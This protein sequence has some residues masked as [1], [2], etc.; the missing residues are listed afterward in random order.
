[1]IPEATEDPTLEPPAMKPQAS[2][3]LS[4]PLSL[5]LPLRL[6]LPPPL[7]PA[8]PH[9]LE[10]DR[11][12]TQELKIS[13]RHSFIRKYVQLATLRLKKKTHTKIE[14]EKQHGCHSNPC[15]IPSTAG[16]LKATLPV[17]VHTYF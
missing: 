5:N 7:R 13:T 6:R 8:P 11:L 10:D 15:H 12:D 4:P 17:K 14:Y 16:S 3:E 1:M 2:G 9:C